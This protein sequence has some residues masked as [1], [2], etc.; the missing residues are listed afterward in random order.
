VNQSS[1][2]LVGILLAAVAWVLLLSASL[3]RERAVPWFSI[4]YNCPI[5][6]A[7]AGLLSNMLL[8]AMALGRERA[9]SAY[10]PIALVWCG[11]AVLLFL[12][13][14]TK[15]IDVSGHMSWA[16]LMGVQCLVERLP[17]WFT[18]FVWLMAVHVFLLKLFVLGGQSGQNGLL[19][20][21]VLGATLW[22]STRRY[23]GAS[24]S[25]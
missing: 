5:T 19:V 14:V 8:S 12:R 22:L 6:L 13:L 4:S 16:I 10:G 24:W 21:G 9:I 2:L 3:V 25:G 20:G 7:F 15:S 11:G 18:S 1:R 17:R 23:W